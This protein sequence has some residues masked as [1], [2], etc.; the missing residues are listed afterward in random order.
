MNEY[1]AVIRS[2]DHLAHYGVKGMKWGVR[3][4]IARGNERALDRHFR[5]AVKK[6]RKLQDIGLHSGKYA[7]K[8]AAY[9]VAAAGT[10]TLAIGGTKITSKVLTKLAKATPEH[11]RNSAAL[12][13]SKINGGKV[14]SENK[15]AL[16]K[17]YNSIR[18]GDIGTGVENWGKKPGITKVVNDKK[19]TVLSNDALYRIGAGVITAG[20]AAKSAQNAYRAKNG[21]KYRQKASEFK[22]AMDNEFAGTKYAGKYVVPPKRKKKRR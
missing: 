9:G 22:N 16:I 8:S 1:Y 21:A 6:L 14:T 10:G 17:K 7:A 19:A 20:L 2:T 3:K 4:A 13:F 11:F 15:Q 18:S 5:K 12:A